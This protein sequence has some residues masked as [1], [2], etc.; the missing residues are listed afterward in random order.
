[1]HVHERRGRAGEHQRRDE[2]EVDDAVQ[3]HAYPYGRSGR[4][5][6]LSAGSSVSVFAAGGSDWTKTTMIRKG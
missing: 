1:M 3:H 5:Q 6:P 4:C 2:Q